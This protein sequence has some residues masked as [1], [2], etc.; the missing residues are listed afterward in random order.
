MGERALGGPWTPILGTLGLPPWTDVPGGWIC[1][2][3]P[4]DQG[5]G[6]LVLPGLEKGRRTSPQ[7]ALSREEELLPGEVGNKLPVYEGMQAQAGSLI[8]RGVTEG[9]EFSQLHLLVPSTRCTGGMR[10]YLAT[11]ALHPGGSEF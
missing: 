5:R 4:S 3:A 6:E 1:H 7:A 2:R 10:Q 8:T 11:W 9:L